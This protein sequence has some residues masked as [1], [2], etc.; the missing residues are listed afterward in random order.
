VPMRCSYYPQ[1]LVQILCVIREFG[2][3]IWRSWPESSGHTD[4]TCASH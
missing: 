2:S 4:P 3:W 1:S